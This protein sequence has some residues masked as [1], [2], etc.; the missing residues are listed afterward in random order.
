[1]TH[2]TSENIMFTH[3][4]VARMNQRGIT[5]KMIMLALQYG[6]RRKDKVILS[7]KKIKNILNKVDR[8]L[9]KRLL[10]LLDKGGITVV[11]SDARVVVTVYNCNKKGITV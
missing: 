11:L 4:A 1:M 7:M 2:T 10:K 9:R 6:N 8:S 3:H 5:K